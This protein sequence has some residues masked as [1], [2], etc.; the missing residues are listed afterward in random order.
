M[1]NCSYSAYSSCIL[2]TA[3]Y[4]SCCAII[5]TAWRCV[6]RVAYARSTYAIPVHHFLDP[7]RDRAASL[8]SPLELP[9]ARLL[10]REGGV[11]PAAGRRPSS[12]VCPPCTHAR[13]YSFIYF[14]LRVAG[15][16][17]FYFFLY[18]LWELP[19]ASLT[20]RS[21]DS[22]DTSVRIVISIFAPH[23]STR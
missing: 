9:V 23:R 3:V 2:A 7:Q 22:S 1:Y 8:L 11:S 5:S 6:P 4:S 19:F 15:S 18:S 10:W 12:S 20:L 17:G 21:S 14:F 16:L 13:L